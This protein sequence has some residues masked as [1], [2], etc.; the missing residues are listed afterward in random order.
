[1]SRRSLTP[2]VLPADPAA[3]M[4]AATKQYVD[5]S[6]GGGHVV[7]PTEPATPADGLLWVNP[8]DEGIS[9]D[10]GVTN[11]GRIPVG[12]IVMHAGGSTPVGWLLCIGG[13]ASRTTEAA[14]FAQIGTI[15][16]VGNG[17]TTF[18]LPD[19][20]GRVPRGVAASGYGD[21]A[22]E[23]FGTDGHIHPL[24]EHAHYIDPPNTATTTGDPD[25]SP[26]SGS[27]APY[28][29]SSYMHTHDVNIAPFWS[30]GVQAAYNSTGPT[31]YPVAAAAVN[32][33][34]KT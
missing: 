10:V 28:N 11:T 16:G 9:D 1:M 27:G 7:D 2:I 4:E 5:A 18:G 33:I 21:A 29:L 12:T 15:W 34:I 31:D 13:T 26:P 19:L 14:M 3:A 17:T 20:R 8:L 25:S 22:G 32:F 24:S 6:A 23:S 30:G